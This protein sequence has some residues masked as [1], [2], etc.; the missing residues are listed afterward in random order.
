MR[1]LCYLYYCNGLL[2]FFCQ[3]L[4]VQP[5]TSDGV[6]LTQGKLHVYTEQPATQSL[7]PEALQPDS[8]AQSQVTP[9]A[10]A[11]D[12]ETPAFNGEF[13]S[14]GDPEVY[15][16][17]ATIT[18]PKEIPPVESTPATLKQADTSTMGFNSGGDI[19]MGGGPSDLVDLTT[20]VQPNSQAVID[21]PKRVATDSNVPGDGDLLAMMNPNSIEQTITGGAYSKSRKRVSSSSKPQTSSKTQ[22][23]QPVSVA[24]SS[25][26]LRKR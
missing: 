18:I 9:V 11:L 19:D 7:H 3:I 2:C 24:A 12:T 13:G 22:F 21:P 17:E 15:S 5:S 20:A 14:G 8:P 16:N 25:S 10:N 4:V 6:P 1:Y 23:L 26:T